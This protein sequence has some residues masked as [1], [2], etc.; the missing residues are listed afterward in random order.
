[1]LFIILYYTVLHFGFGFIIPIAMKL[2]IRNIILSIQVNEIPLAKKPH[3]EE[4]GEA[5]E[6]NNMESPLPGPQILWDATFETLP[7]IH[8]DI[9]KI[10]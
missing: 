2:E 8:Y 1:M 6:K 4:V 7:K 3:L 10:V 5:K 9:F